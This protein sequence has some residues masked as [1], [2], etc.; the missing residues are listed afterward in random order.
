MY[1]SCLGISG[2]T[3]PSSVLGLVGGLNS[4]QI[5]PPEAWD[6]NDPIIAQRACPGTEDQI[7]IAVPFSVPL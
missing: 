4:S 3:V 6:P 2:S 5:S 7:P 1:A